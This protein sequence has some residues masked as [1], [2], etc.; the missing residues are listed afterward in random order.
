MVAV[1]I[2]WIVIS[3]FAGL[4][5]INKGR[6][7]LGFLFLSLFLS[8]LIG[9]IAVLLAKP[10]PKKMREK[11]NV[12][13]LIK[14]LRRGSG[15]IREQA[16][17]ALT[18]K[19]D[20]NFSPKSVELLIHALEDK[21]DIIRATAAKALGNIGDPRA[22]EPLAHMLTDKISYVRAEAVISLGKKG[23]H[24]AIEPLFSILANPTQADY[25]IHNLH[26]AALWWNYSVENLLDNLDVPTKRLINSFDDPSENENVRAYAASAL[27]KRG[28]SQT[29]SLLI[30]ALKG[31][32]D[33]VRLRAAE[34]LGK[35]K[36]EKAVEALILAL[37][38]SSTFVINAA[39]R[40]LGMIG[41]QRATKPLINL[42]LPYIKGE[43]TQIDRISTC[44]ALLKIDKDN[45]QVRDVVKKVKQVMKDKIPLGWYPTSEAQDF[46]NSDP[47][48]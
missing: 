13:G 19:Q 8:P 21:D 25:K 47:S 24:R 9:I 41:D 20:I 2:L 17:S 15:N 32:H 5:A 43:M 30:S 36:D 40:S 42:L 4:I 12:F 35:L 28:G 45:K 34:G 14:V 18:D 11:S 7:C 46:F 33:S 23:D 44:E 26:C 10:N 3:I 39:A 48:I 22:T 38:D 6:S 29:V 16:Y 27:A 37:K 1:V 31:K